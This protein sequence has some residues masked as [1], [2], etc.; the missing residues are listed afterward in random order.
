MTQIIKINDTLYQIKRII[1]IT[2]KLDIKFLKEYW[3][4]DTALKGTDNKMYFCN[5]ID[6]IEF[7]EIKN[8]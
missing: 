2:E 4:C 3:G 5:I 1:P 6:N 7:E 8:E